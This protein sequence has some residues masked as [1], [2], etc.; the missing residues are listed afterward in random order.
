[1]K[2]KI[3]FYINTFV[4][5]GIE[6]VLIE[7]LV[8]IDKTKFEIE[9]LIGFK[10][11]ELE[12]MKEQIPK[13][14]KIDY[15]MKNNFFCQNK[16]KKSLGVLKS[17][18]KII[19]E[20]FS[21]LKKIIFLK[22][23]KNKIKDKEVIVDFDM[24]LASYIKYIP[25]KMITFCHF[26]PKNY[27]RGIK[28]RQ[29]KLGKRLNLYD[30]IIV[31]SDDM[32]KEMIE[33]FPFLKNKVKR[34]YNSF[35][36]DR[37]KKLSLQ[38]INDKKILEKYILAIG[39]LEE[40]QKDFTSLIKAY[41]LI[42]KNIKEKL[43]IIGE[44]RHKDNLIKLCEELNIKDRVIFL[45][46][47]ENPYPWLRET[48]LFIHSS[49]FEGL[50]T[51]M[52]EALILEKLIIATNCPTGPKEILDNGKNGILVEVGDIKELAISIEKLLKSNKKEYYI[53]NLKEKIKEFDSK[54]VIKQ[55][56]E[57]ISKI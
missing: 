7:N 16:K 25:K 2:K 49:K 4:V 21:W 35:N 55:L 22:K 56:E 28:R 1:M 36:I 17:Y 23:L 41:S 8:N 29:V 27:N 26:S 42:E 53:K 43:Y 47:K 15:I 32:K 12:K 37:I 31:I 20:S 18:E 45:G 9:L 52:I 39:R 3:C 24:T 30:K 14:I 57:I 54:I 13:D 50:P 48:S 44:G 40:T 46:F 5:G 51:V 19:D 38:N 11:D 33:I 34:I 6:K 10:L